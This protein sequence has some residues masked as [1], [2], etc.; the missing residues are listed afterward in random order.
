MNPASVEPVATL[1][2]PQGRDAA[3]LP[4]EAARARIE[5]ARWYWLTTLHPR[6]RPHTRPVLAVW[7]GGAL[8][9]TSSRTAQK[10]R[11]LHA[12]PSCSVA[13]LADDMHIVIEG[14][15]I[16][17]ENGGTLDMVAATYRSKYD[18]PVSVVEGGFDAPYA[19]PAAGPAPYVPFGITPMVVYGWGTS[20]LIGPRHTCW[21]FRV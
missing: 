11:N 10:G 2:D 4:W 9:T 17:V 19:A 15:A 14:S 6:G 8:Y 21:R 13:V 20:G 5:A 16:A 7:A 12:D 3:P 18:W 1:L